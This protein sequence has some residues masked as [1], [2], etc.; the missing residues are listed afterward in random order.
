MS[1]HEIDVRGRLKAFLDRRSVPKNLDGKPTAYAAELDAL[2]RAIMRRAPHAPEL[3]EWWP[4]F[5]ERVAEINIT[6][7]WPTEGEV[8][9]AADA[10][11]PD[12]TSSSRAP[13][14]TGIEF[15]L[16]LNA[17]RIREGQHVGD[18]WIYGKGAAELVAAGKITLDDLRPYRSAMFFVAKD[19]YP[20]EMAKRM[21]RD[22]IKRYADAVAAVAAP[23]VHRHLA[24]PDKRGDKTEAW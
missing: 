21:E 12:R 5:E 15:S 23:R 20:E 22:W 24:I 3:A 19:T 9:K 8:K 11:A 18:D 6:R 10:I 1:L 7:L 17:K 16:T 4:R 14:A 13:E 2:A